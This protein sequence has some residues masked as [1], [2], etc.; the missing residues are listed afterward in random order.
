MCGFLPWTFAAT[1][2]PTVMAGIAG[3]D[4]Q[5]QPARRGELEQLLEAHPCLDLD[6]QLRRL[7][8]EHAVEPGHVQDQAAASEARRSVRVAAAPRDHAALASRRLD[9]P[10]AVG[11]VERGR[12]AVATVEGMEGGRLGRGRGQRCAVGHRQRDQ[13]ADV[14]QRQ[15]AT[16]RVE[17]ASITRVYCPP[18]MN[19]LVRYAAAIYHLGPRQAARNLFHRATRATRAFERYTRVGSGLEWTGQ[20]ADRLPG[21]RR[22][23]AARA[24]ALHGRRAHAAS[25][26]IRRTGSSTPRCCGSSISTTSRG[27]MRCR[28][29]RAAPPRDRLDRAVPAEREP[30][31]LDAV[32]AQPAAAALGDALVRRGRLARVPSARALFASIEAQAEC[33][34]DTLEH[35]LRGNHLLESAI[36]LKLLS[37]CFRGPAV[38]R[39]ERRAEAVLD[40]ELA[41]QFLLDG[42][43]IERSPM[44]HA[45][46]AARAARPAERPAG[47]RRDA[48]ADRAATARDPAL[49]LGACATRTVRSRSSATAAFGIAP[50]PAAIL[51]YARRLGLDVPAFA[52]GSFP[53][54]GYHVWRAGG[55][56]LIV[57]AGPIGPDYL[58]AHGHGDIFSFE[59]SLDG[60]RVVVDGGT[61]SYEAGA[62]RDWARSTR[63]H[64]TVEIAGADQAEFF[65]AFRVGR[66]GRPRDVVGSRL[67]RRPAGLRM[68][69][70]LPAPRRPPD[71][72]PRAGARGAGSALSS[73]TRSSLPCRR[74]RC[75]GSDS[76]RARGC[77]SRD[78]TSAAIEAAGTDARRCIR[79][80][81]GWR[82][83]TASTRSASAS[84]WPVR[85]WRST[86][87]R[88][89]SSATRSRARS[90]RADRRRGRAGRRVGRCSAG[91]DGLRAPRSAA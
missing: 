27:S 75:R 48:G 64:N 44:Y 82:S 6:Q 9:G 74:R 39:W 35:H 78:R 57:D 65:G 29:D 32:P 12:L 66:R 81:R 90:A 15:R 68:A 91:A 52:S 79:S 69:R 40:A 26:A 20:R 45:R 16:A 33:L 70:R 84:A 34:A 25:S 53:E 42:G 5:D 14:A 23:R 36:T 55:D 28:A 54:T 37:A 72:P 71:P 86:R 47:G 73:G 38:A 30:A 83:R 76:R 50:E 85:C 4:R 7:E 31:R 10:V 59:L 18:L 51:D 22:W 67:G 8:A 11:P 60:Q 62:E 58:P 19:A 24:R 87:A 17:P 56:A 1:Q 41:E 13:H 63:A 43:H 2:P 21:A 49:R 89:P 80:A 61:S 3:L 46:L 88:G 77:G